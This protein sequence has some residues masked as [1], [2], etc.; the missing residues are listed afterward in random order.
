MR[1]KAL[2]NSCVPA[3]SDMDRQR[4]VI[5][6]LPLGRITF[7]PLLTSH[8]TTNVFPPTTPNL[9][10]THTHTRAIEQ[11]QDGQGRE[12]E[13]DFFSV[14][15]EDEAALPVRVPTTTEDN[16]EA[17]LRAKIKRTSWPEIRATLCSRSRLPRS[18]QTGPSPSLMPSIRAKEAAGRIAPWP[19]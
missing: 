6:S 10:K 17:G 19:R 16:R 3:V 7:Q 9:R 18:R 12:E 11:V 2:A 1:V 15:S 5:A 13:A 14:S 4:M 8:F